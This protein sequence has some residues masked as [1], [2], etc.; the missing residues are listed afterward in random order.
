[1]QKNLA[2]CPLA[3]TAYAH[4]FLRKDGNLH[5]KCVVLCQSAPL[6]W[7]LSLDRAR[8][9][10]DILAQLLDAHHELGEDGLR[11][12]VP[13]QLHALPLELKERVQNTRGSGVAHLVPLHHFVGVLN[14]EPSW[15]N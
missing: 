4:E 15:R 9:Q 7:Q 3:C 1:L 8:E 14:S 11:P 13:F 10:R 6:H 5:E 2:K 12:E